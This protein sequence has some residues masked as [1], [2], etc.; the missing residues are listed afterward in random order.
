M[1]H[2]SNNVIGIINLITFLLSIPILGGGIWLATKE[3]SDYD[4]FLQRP[5][6]VIRAFLVLVSLAGLVGACCRIAWL[7]WLYL[8]VMF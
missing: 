1:V 2:F 3:D 5:F 4:K 6:M 8:T 7:L